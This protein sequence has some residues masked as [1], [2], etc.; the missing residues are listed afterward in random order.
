MMSPGSDLALIDDVPVAGAGAG[1]GRHQSREVRL[2]FRAAPARRIDVQHAPA[3]GRLRLRPRADPRRLH[4]L[5]AHAVRILHRQPHL[6]LGV[7][8]EVEDAAGESIG[9][10]VRG[11][12]D[13]LAAHPQ[14]RQRRLPLVLRSD[15]SG[16]PVGDRRPSRCGCRRR[17][18]PTRTRG[19]SASA[20]P[21]RTPPPSQHQIVGCFG[22]ASPPSPHRTRDRSKAAARTRRG[23]CSWVARGEV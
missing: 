1:V 23:G 16:A 6:V 7:R 5:S 17:R 15:R 14:Q 8:L 10:G 12:E 19:R 22:A 9:H 20:A 13:L 2:L 3:G 4:R 21:R 18:S 11:A